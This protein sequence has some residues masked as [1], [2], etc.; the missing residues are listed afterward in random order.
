MFMLDDV[1]RRL[2]ITTGSWDDVLQTM[3]DAAR[4]AADDFMGVRYSLE[5]DREEYHDGGCPTIYL[6]HVNVSD[7]VVTHDSDTVDEDAY[8]LY[9]DEGVLCTKYD[10]NW[11]GGKRSIR[12]V[13][14]GGYSED[15]LPEA[16]R[17]KLI[18]QVVYEFRRRKDPGL[19]SVQFPDGSVQ[20]FVIG[21]WLPDVEAELLR[22]RRVFL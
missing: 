9:P 16:L 3:I 7:L 12:A 15:D 21:E 18:K 17:S 10:T 22:R 11:P 19:S 4:A 6:G 13:Y 8:V 1:R 2:E 5:A 14:S 20:K